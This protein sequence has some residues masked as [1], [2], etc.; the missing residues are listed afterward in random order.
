M[1]PGPHY[2]R[3]VAWAIGLRALPAPMGLCAEATDEESGPA[4]QGEA[5]TEA[6]KN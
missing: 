4:G 5:T 1:L 2:G 6:G 3:V